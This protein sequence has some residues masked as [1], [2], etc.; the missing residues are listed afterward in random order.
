MSEKEEETM[1]QSPINYFKNCYKY[2]SST[3][4][5][6]IFDR[7]D[8]IDIDQLET[9]NSLDLHLSRSLSL[10][11]QSSFLGERTVA[12]LD[13]LLNQIDDIKQSVFEID[14]D[15]VNVG[16]KTFSTLASINGTEDS[17][18]SEDLK[19]CALTSS[20]EWDANDIYLLN[21]KINNS[22]LNCLD[23]NLF[24]DVITP[25]L[26]QLNRSSS[27]FTSSGNGSSFNSSE[28]SDTLKI[29]SIYD[30]LEE[31]KKM[32]ILNDLI[33]YLLK[34]VKKSQLV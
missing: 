6:L 8:F 16:N 20:L 24:K 11:S 1:H 30:F 27:S 14:A 15:L 10:Y 31:A 23:E 18:E 34:N 28:Q 32:G 22:L 9:Y 19:E 33:K 12:K 4:H 26:T 5:P 25:N 7:R 17:E 29:K 3:P 21:E 13:Q 2:Y